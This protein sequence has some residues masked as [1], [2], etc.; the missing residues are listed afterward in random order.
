MIILFINKFL[1]EDKYSNPFSQIIPKILA[2]FITSILIVLSITPAFIKKFRSMQVFQKIRKENPKSHLKKNEVPTFGGALILF[3]IIF[4]IL[5]WSDI[6][7]EYVRYILFSLISYGTIGFIDDYKKIVHQ[8]PTGLKARWKYFW[9]SFSALFILII[10]YKSGNFHNSSFEQSNT[11][12]DVDVFI[13]IKLTISYLAIVGMSNAVN[14]MDGLDGLVLMPT[15]FVCISFAITS[16]LKIQNFTFQNLTNAKLLIISNYSEITI[17]CFSMIGSCIGFLWF[18][19]YPAKLFM[20]DIGSL[21][22]GGTIGL[23]SV[24][25]E[26]E[27]DLLIIGGIFVIE[28]VSVILQVFHIK[29]FH[30]RLYLMAPIHHHYELLDHSEPKIVFKFWIM[31]LA[32]TILGSLIAWRII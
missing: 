6:N 7:I 12:A 17:I 13:F 22:L 30:K 10:L 24:L 1:L 5:L 20:G 8:D 29:F 21:S 3:S 16:V 2:S 28:I 31:S 15:I 25:L 14:I 11:I 23:I 9:Q 26:Q 18:N 32:F 19:S 4:S 27:L